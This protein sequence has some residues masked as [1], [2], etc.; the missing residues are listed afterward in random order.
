MLLKY[1]F[2][3]DLKFP[4]AS[5]SLLNSIVNRY[6]SVRF[7]ETQIGFEIPRILA[8][9]DIA[10]RLLHTHYDHVTPLRTVPTLLQKHS[11][12]K[13]SAKMNFRKDEV[14][15]V[16]AALSKEFQEEYKH[17]KSESHSI[18]EEEIKDEEQVD[19]EVPTVGR[20]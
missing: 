4:Q 8:T 18:H 5:S 2:T 12:A 19:I 3:A 15:N 14:K 1:K 13:N 16:E 7:S 20:I 9:S 17:R 10:L 6:R 11:S